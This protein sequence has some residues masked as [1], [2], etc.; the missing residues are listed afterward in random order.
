MSNLE[1]R[2]KCLKDSVKYR[3]G[4][5]KIKGS[6]MFPSS[7]YGVKQQLSSKKRSTSYNIDE[8]LAITVKNLYNDKWFLIIDDSQRSI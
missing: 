4:K 8:T 1:Y 6:L 2:S 3:D 7:F 5:Y